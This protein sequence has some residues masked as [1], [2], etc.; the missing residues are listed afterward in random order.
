MVIHDLFVRA[1]HFASP[2]NCMVTLVVVKCA[3]GLSILCSLA[4]SS[5]DGNLRITAAERSCGTNLSTGF[6]VRSIPHH[7][8]VVPTGPLPPVA[9]LPL[10][11]ASGRHVERLPCQVVR[12]VFVITCHE[13]VLRET[14]IVVEHCKTRRLSSLGKLRF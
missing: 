11:A 14:A 3:H 5:I 1:G 12:R 8:L 9:V 10:Q 4:L 2:M 13:E 7:Y 6:L